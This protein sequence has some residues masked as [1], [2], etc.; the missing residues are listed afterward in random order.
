MLYRSAAGVSLRWPAS[1]TF[2]HNLYA[3]LKA[4]MQRRG[5][6]RSLNRIGADIESVNQLV[7]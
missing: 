2:R 3:F 6:T 7:E 4:A 5:R 1:A